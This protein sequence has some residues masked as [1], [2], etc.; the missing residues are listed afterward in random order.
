MLW[1]NFRRLGDGL[2]TLGGG[3]KFT[4]VPQFLGATFFHGTGFVLN[5]TRNWLGHILTFSQTH[6]VTHWMTVCT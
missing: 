6:L 2:Y 5:L 3:L 4:E 1:A